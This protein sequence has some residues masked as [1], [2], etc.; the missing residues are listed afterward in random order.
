LFE[1]SSLSAANANLRYSVSHS[2]IARDSNLLGYDA[3]SLGCVFVLKVQSVLE[4][5]LLHDIT[6]QTAVIVV[7]Y[8]C[9][10]EHTG[11]IG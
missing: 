7:P 5:N 3:V 1:V 10:P 8:S 11:Y 6:E 4:A 9:I 2:G